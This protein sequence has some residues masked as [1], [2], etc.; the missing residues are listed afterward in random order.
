MIGEIAIVAAAYCLGSLPTALLLVRRLK[1]MDVRRLGS[2]NIGATNAARV[3]GIR[4]GAVVTVV[5]VLKGALPVLLMSWFNPASRWLALTMLAA[6]LGHIFPVWLKFRG[7]KG[8]A[9]GF[10]A[11]LVIAPGP[12]GVAFLVWLV[13]VVLSRHVALA[14][15]LASAV[16]PTLLYWIE[17]P[18]EPILWSVVVVAALIVVRHSSNMKNLIKGTEPKIGDEKWH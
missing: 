5:D 12:A 9:T 2:G 13:V 11:F 18:P 16:F 8:V 15:M 1:G 14:S 10:G 6:V 3:A 4:I 17:R 7:G